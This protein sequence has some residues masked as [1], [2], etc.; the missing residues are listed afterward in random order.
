VTHFLAMVVQELLNPLAQRLGVRSG[1]RTVG[2]VLLALVAAAFAAIYV[3]LCAQAGGQTLPAWEVLARG[4][5]WAIL[6]PPAFALGT[7]ALLARRAPG[8]AWYVV[9]ASGATNVALWATLAFGN[10][11]LPAGFAF[12]G[13]AALAL[14]LGLVH[15]LFTFV[16][17]IGQAVPLNDPLAG[18]VYLGRIGHLRALYRMAQQHAWPVQGP[19]GPQHTLTVEGRYGERAVYVESGAHMSMSSVDP[20]YAFLK[21]SVYSACRLWPLIVQT[22]L[23]DRNRLEGY[24]RATS[25]HDA[26]WLPGAQVQDLPCQLGRGTVARLWA[27]PG[28]QLTPASLA[29]VARAIEQAPFM[30][31]SRIWYNKRTLFAH[32]DG[33]RWERR[34]GLRLSESADDVERII[35]WVASIVRAMEEA[36]LATERSPGAGAVPATE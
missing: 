30:N 15:W 28:V 22:G 9:L 34:H 16:L 8:N 4:G 31:N 11:L 19:D 32:G 26:P 24:L 25:V 2:N 7:I 13:G 18:L 5:S 36:G 3:L 17:A 6:L 21:I 33:L 20:G 35:A 12:S 10:A 27:P 14:I 1:C 23:P 29:W